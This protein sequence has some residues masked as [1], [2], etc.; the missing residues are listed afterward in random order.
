MKRSIFIITYALIIFSMVLGCAK[1]DP[2]PGKKPGVPGQAAPEKPSVGPAA[3]GPSLDPLAGSWS[4]TVQTSDKTFTISFNLSQGC[5][6]NAKCG[7]FFIPDFD[8]G[9]D[10]MFTTVEGDKYIFVVSNLSQE[11]GAAAYEEWLRVINNNELEY[12]SRGEYGTST[13][14]LTRK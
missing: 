13:G 7:D 6:L 14:T 12:Y 9:G 8:L 11:V 3:A 2:V 10:V 1:A 5:Q 4:G